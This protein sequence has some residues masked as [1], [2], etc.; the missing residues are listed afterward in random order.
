MFL[1]AIL[2]VAEMALM[3]VNMLKFTCSRHSIE[4]TIAALLI[5]EYQL[6]HV[7]VWNLHCNITVRLLI[8][9]HLFLPR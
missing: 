1:A 4:L 9:G 5:S 7:G 3:Q 6:L 2:Q 8:F